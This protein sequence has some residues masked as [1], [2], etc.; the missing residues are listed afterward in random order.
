M[1]TLFASATLKLT[2]WYLLILMVLSL[3]FSSIL[4][5]ISSNELRRSLRAGPGP[6]ALFLDTEQARELRETRQQEGATRLLGNLVILNVSTLV[7]GGGVSYLLARRT[8]RPIHESMQAQGRFTSDASHE[9]RTPLAIMQS[10]IE[11]G[12]RDTSATKKDYQ[13]LLRSNLDEVN[14]LR[15][16]SDRLLLLASERELPLA[17]ISLDDVSIEA[18][19]RIVKAAQAKHI[20]VAN[21]VKPIKVIA[22]PEALADAVTI[23][24]DNALKYSPAKTTVTMSSE[25][26]GRFVNLRVADQGQGIAAGDLPYIF[27]RFYRADTS[28]TRQSVEG[29]GL[30]LSIAQRIVEQHGG[31][32]SVE[33]KPGHGAMF[34]IRLRRA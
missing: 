21:E 19:G 11:V 15:E 20:T 30:G 1:N 10:E 26:Q 25:T 29:H 16:L 17:A 7:V 24:L 4:Y 27:D 33:S 2:L 32:L 18:T 8:L 5:G 6:G 31:E 34:T 22:N 14:R 9:L 23:L 13:T 28:R 12:L 3:L